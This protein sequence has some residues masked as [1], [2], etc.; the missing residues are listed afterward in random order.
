MNSEKEFFEVTKTDGKN[1]DTIRYTL[2]V[3]K[4]K[5]DLSA[6]KKLDYH[7]GA[8]FL[9]T[10]PV[11]LNQDE[12]LMKNYTHCCIFFRWPIIISNLVYESKQRSSRLVLQAPDVSPPRLLV[13]FGQKI[14]DLHA[15]WM[16]IYAQP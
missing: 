11:P 10:D 4:S 7:S 1:G 12:Y 15:E 6:K 8:V 2:S 3:M 5:S 16:T 14:F 13:R 9:F